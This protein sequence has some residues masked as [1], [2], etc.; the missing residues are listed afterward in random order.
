MSEQLCIISPPVVQITAPFIPKVKD[1]KDTSN[2][3]DYPDSDE[4]TA[5]RLTT[6][7]L[8]LFAE[9]DTF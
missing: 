4:D 9:F 2:F 1:E 8:E 5:G 7:E 6:K 3:D